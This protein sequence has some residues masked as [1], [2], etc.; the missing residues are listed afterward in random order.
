MSADHACETKIVRRILLVTL[1]IASIGP[2]L[3][4][5]GSASAETDTVPP[6]PAASVGVDE[7]SFQGGAGSVNYLFRITRE[8]NRSCSLHGYVHVSFVGVYGYGFEP[9]KNAQPLVVKQAENH[10]MDGNDFGGLAPGL[11]MPTV[12]LS[13]TKSTASL[14]IYGVDHSTSGPNGVA[15]RCITSFEMRLQLPGDARSLVARL[16]PGQGFYFCGTVNVH[17]IVPGSSGS[18]PA[19]KPIFHFN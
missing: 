13:S 14:W 9:L 2:A 8:G 1:L 19:K 12:D 7:Y 5:S 4:S 6:C 15:S 10:G 17:P 18:D 11:S 16:A 3:A